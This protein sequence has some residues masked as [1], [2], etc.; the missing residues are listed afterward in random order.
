ML[1]NELKDHRQTKYRPCFISAPSRRS[2][3]G[4]ASPGGA[5]RRGKTGV[6][7][8]RVAAS[9]DPEKV[10]GSLAKALAG[11]RD[12]EVTASGEPA[13]ARLLLALGLAQAFTL[14]NGGNARVKV[15]DVDL[16]RG[17]VAVLLTGEFSRH[18]PSCGKS[19]A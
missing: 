4:I 9:S 11:G 15:G 1:S 3:S 16:G 10:A 7:H 5:S 8:T 6:F 18:S 14:K 13:L 2:R 12:V 17:S 19:S